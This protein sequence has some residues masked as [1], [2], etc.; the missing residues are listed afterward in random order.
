MA[1]A[2]SKSDVTVNKATKTERYYTMGYAP[3][4]GRPTRRPPSTSRAAGWLEESE[5]MTG[6]PI[7]VERGRL[8]I[9]T[10]INL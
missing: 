3:H 10:E 9:E 8:V 2:H 4:N 1:K 5:F 6:M 7:T